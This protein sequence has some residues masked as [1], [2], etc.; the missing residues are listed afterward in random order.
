MLC[1]IYYTSR[2]TN[3][4]DKNVAHTYLSQTHIHTQHK[5]RHH[6]PMLLKMHRV[7]TQV[8]LAAN[9]ESSN[10]N[11]LFPFLQRVT[12]IM[13][14]CPEHHVLSLILTWIT[15]FFFYFCRNSCR[16]NHIVEWLILDKNN[17]YRLHIRTHV[18]TETLDQP[19]LPLHS[20][21]MRANKIR[22]VAGRN[23]VSSFTTLT[24]MG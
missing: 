10:V 3:N 2:N 15:I 18:Y 24:T 16:P 22:H 20:I 8:S 7:N 23:C 19:W 9:Y 14:P 5:R 4:Y 11:W 6:T 17:L 12:A 1:Y 13:P 21:V